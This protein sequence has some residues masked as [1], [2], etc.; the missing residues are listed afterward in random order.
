MHKLLERCGKCQYEKDEIK[1]E[2]K[3]MEKSFEFTKKK[4]DVQSKISAKQA[5]IIDQINLIIEFD[6]KHV[7]NDE[8]TEIFREEDSKQINLVDYL[9]KS[10]EEIKIIEKLKETLIK[11]NKQILNDKNS[12]IQLKSTLMNRLNIEKKKNDFLFKQGCKMKSIIEKQKNIIHQKSSHINDLLNLYR[13]LSEKIKRSSNQNK[14]LNGDLNERFNFMPNDKNDV[15][16][17]IYHST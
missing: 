16:E 13:N 9:N 2:L 10:I 17:T 15:N 6:E 1:K 14:Q 12:M 7:I 11:K 8:K 3:N 4:L 5:E